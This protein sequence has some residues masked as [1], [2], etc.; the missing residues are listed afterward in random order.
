LLK[1]AVAKDIRNGIASEGRAQKSDATSLFYRR[2]PLSRLAFAGLFGAD[3]ATCHKNAL[4]RH[5]CVAL[6]WLLWLE[7]RV[8]SGG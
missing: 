5:H 6:G 1:T 7:T 3:V 2:Q 8:E 4:M